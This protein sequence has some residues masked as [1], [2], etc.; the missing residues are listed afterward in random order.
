MSHDVNWADA[1]T[2]IGTAVTAIV[3]IYAAAT[4]QRNMREATRHE[5]AANVLEQA[6]LFR[7]LFYDARNPLYLEGEFPADYHS[8]PSEQRN[9]ALKARAWAHVYENRWKLLEPQMLKLATVRAR[10]GAVLGDDVA[11][12]IEQLAKKGRQLQGYFQNRVEQIRE[13]DELVA[14]YPD[15]NWV[16]RVKRSVRAN[17]EPATRDDDYSKE[18]EEKFAALEQLVRPFI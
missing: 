9:D 12:A 5:T 15:Q 14:L 11:E 6:R 1:M 13:G 8:V 3:A 18:F 2:A 10:A 16:K 7:Y 17:V 4:W